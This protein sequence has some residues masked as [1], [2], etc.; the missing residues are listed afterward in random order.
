MID[1]TARFST[2]GN[3]VELPPHDADA[4][5]ALLGGLMLSGDLELL[6]GVRATLGGEDFY[7]PH[8]RFIWAAI[9]GNA[10]AG[11]PFD[12]V[13]IADMLTER[14]QLE[15]VGG[16]AELMEILEAVPHAQHT[17][18]YAGIIKK[19]A[20][21][22]MAMGRLRDA[23]AIL[24]DPT[25][26][27]DEAVELLNLSD[28]LTTSR[29]ERFTWLS[30][31]D[32][33]AG[34]Y[35]QQYLVPGILAAGVPGIVAGAFKAL[36]TSITLSLHLS[37]SNGM[38]FLGKFD[39][40][41]HV[42][43]AFMSGES[44]LSA[45][46]NAAERISRSMGGELKNVRNFWLTSDL[47]KLDSPSDIAALER[48]ITER[49][50]RLLSIDPA[51]LCCNVADDAHNLFAMAQFLKPVGELCQRTGCTILLLHHCKRGGAIGEP[52]E[53]AD[54][55]WSGWAEFAA[56]WLLLSRRSKFDPDTGRHELW[57]NAGGRAGHAGIWAVDVHEGRE[58]DIDGRRWEPVVKNATDARTADACLAA[59]KRHRQREQKEQDQLEADTEKIVDY[60]RHFPDGET[61]KGIREGTGIRTAR[62]GAAISALLESGRIESCSVKKHTRTESGFQLST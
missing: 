4:E 39:V 6:R 57:L 54:I 40:A 45:L 59:E 8:H 38:P 28:L 55:A 62:A 37:L 14:G 18:H 12:V 48:W 19:H 44:G 16:A 1:T 32:M 33:A 23:R 56:Q 24:A 60:L 41:G 49:E 51:Y 17:L 31:E 46:K 61:L 34:E 5:R 47:P 22:R 3:G 15:E 25:R 20:A 10:D 53:L 27:V 21:R 50:I 52:A 35:D 11:R 30:A 7:R 9:L 2:N 42:N 29:R 13:T 58:G 43:T 26:G 36:K